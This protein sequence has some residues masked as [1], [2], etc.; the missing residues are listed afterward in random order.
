MDTLDM[1]AGN[2]IVCDIMTPK[3][4]RDLRREL[5]EM[6]KRKKS[7]RSS[8]L[9]RFAMKL[10]RRKRK[11]GSEP[12][13]VTD[14]SGRFPLSIPGHPGTLPIGTACSILNHLEGDL[15]YLEE[16]LQAEMEGDDDEKA[17]QEN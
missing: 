7:L 13:Y 17:D 12:T 10:G 3:Q 8:E 6:R 11:G 15:N 16:E 14:A 4:L 5:E 9:R 2:D 1:F